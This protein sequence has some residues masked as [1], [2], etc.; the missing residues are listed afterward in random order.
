MLLP[1]T[2]NGLG[3]SQ[4]AFVWLFARVGVSAADAFALS[5]LFV[6]ARRGR[7]S[8]RRAALPRRRG[9]AAAGRQR[10]LMKRVPNDEA[11]PLN[12]LEHKP[13]SPLS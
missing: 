2:V 8:A 4:W 6:G 3:T 10:H 5:I 1:V 7:Q 11:F 9:D 13:H 12:R